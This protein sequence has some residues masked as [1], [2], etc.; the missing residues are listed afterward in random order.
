MMGVMAKARTACRMSSKA[1]SPTDRYDYE[2]SVHE[3]LDRSM[4]K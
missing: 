2:V 4:V 3:K 1:Y